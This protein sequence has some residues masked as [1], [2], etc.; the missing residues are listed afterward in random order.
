M[1]TRLSKRSFTG[2]ERTL[3]AVGTVRLWSMLL[4]VR[5]AAPRMGARPISPGPAAGSPEPAFLPASDFFGSGFFGS[6][7]FGSAF[8]GSDSAFLDSD[9]FGSDSAFL[10]S[11]F[12]G[13]GFFGSAFVFVSA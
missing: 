4:A 7:F 3:V 1:T 6:D 11:D 12:L 2:T 5:A 9:F 8:F 10:D 13:S